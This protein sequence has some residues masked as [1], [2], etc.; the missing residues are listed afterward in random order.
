MNFKLLRKL[1]LNRL[2]VDSKSMDMRRRDFNQA[3]FDANDGAACFY[4][5]DLDMVMEKF[6][7]AIDDYKRNNK[8][9]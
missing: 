2:T 5:I 4:G 7:F 1:F 9:K 8:I 6:D 3:I